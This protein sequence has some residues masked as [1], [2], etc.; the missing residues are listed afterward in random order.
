MRKCVQ[1][2]SIAM[3]NCMHI[4]DSSMLEIATYKPNF[5]YIDI[6]GCKKITDCSIISIFNSNVELE[7]LDISATS[8]TDQG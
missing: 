3:A 1:L 5:K 6:K 8:V 2:D 4:A 7:Y